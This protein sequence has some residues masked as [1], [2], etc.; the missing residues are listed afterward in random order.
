MEVYLLQSCNNKLDVWSRT[1]EPWIVDLCSTPWC[2][3]FNPTWKQQ[4]W[5]G[6]I[7]PVQLCL[8]QYNNKNNSLFSQ[9]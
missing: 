5:T 1:V 4:E 7:E 9:I 6:L 8:D 3:S 2:V